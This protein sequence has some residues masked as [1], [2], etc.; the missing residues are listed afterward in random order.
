MI[1]RAP[2]EYF[3]MD[4][5]IKIHYQK[6]RIM[7]INDNKTTKAIK[8]EFNSMFPHL[9]LEFYKTEHEVEEGSSNEALITEEVSLGSIRKSHSAGD[10]SIHEEMSVSDLEQKF[11]DKFDLNVQVFRKS[12]D[13]WLQTTSTDNWTLK[14]QNSTAERSA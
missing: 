10:F 6:K 1:H 8:E 11:H 12:G 13:I 9:K 2:F 3:W 4:I 7:L 14:Q 5:S